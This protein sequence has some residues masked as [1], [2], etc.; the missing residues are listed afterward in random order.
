MSE[1]AQQHFKQSAALTQTNTVNKPP[2]SQGVDAITGTSRKAPSG[3]TPSR[4]G[5]T[6]DGKKAPSGHT[7]FGHTPSGDGITGD[8]SKAPC[9]R[10]LSGDVSKASLRDSIRA[11]SGGVSMA[12]HWGLGKATPE[13]PTSGGVSSSPSENLSMPPPQDVSK[14]PCGEVTKPPSQYFVKPSFGSVTKP[15]G[16]TV[17]QAPPGGITKPCEVSAQ[18]DQV[19]RSG[20]AVKPPQ[21]ATPQSAVHRQSCTEQHET[22]AG[23]NAV[24]KPSV[25]PQLPGKLLSPPKP[26][27]THTQAA[28]SDQAA[29]SGRQQV[30]EKLPSAAWQ[31][32]M[33]LPSLS[34]LYA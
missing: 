16:K 27:P 2:S 14:P 13:D 18:A 32:Y 25:T 19:K 5:I 9:G 15:P 6:G 8:T 31:V 1:A 21:A 4:V 20:A 11:P 28:Q 23:Q 34:A 10:P 22:L 33:Q 26:T 17:H 3:H 24:S 12:T 29:V 7:S 30:P